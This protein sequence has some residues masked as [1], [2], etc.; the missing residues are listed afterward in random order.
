MIFRALR[1]AVALGSVLAFCIP[2]LW[3][4][5]LRGP[6][7]LERRARWGQATGRQMIASLGIRI[8]VTGHPPNGGLLVSNHLSYLDVLIYGTVLPCFFVS[9]AEIRRWPFF[10]WM[11]RAGGTIYVERSS[12]SSAISVAEQIAERLQGPIS[13]LL[14]PEAPA[15]TAAGCCP[16]APGSSRPRSRPALRSPRPPSVTW[17]PTAPRSG[18]CAG[19]ATR[20]FCLTSGR[21]WE[22]PASPPK[23]P[24][25]SRKSILI[26]APPPIGPRPR[27]PPCGNAA[28]S[29]LNRPDRIFNSIA[30][31]RRRL[32]PAQLAAYPRC[33][34]PNFQSRSSRES[35]LGETAHCRG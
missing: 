2:R 10:G 33:S 15:P 26:A 35:R 29:L 14:F 4:W 32:I 7:T 8:K 13:V 12:R 16:F 34:R 5:R 11:S 21:R 25:A 3:L 28:C 17:L 27:S 20:R 30:T 22:R 23:Y 18:N 6:L 19:S 1:R 31:D 9:K 24:L